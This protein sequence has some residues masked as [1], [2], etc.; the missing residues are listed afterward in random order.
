MRAPATTSLP[1][2][3]T[4]EA[5]VP[6]AFLYLRLVPASRYLCCSEPASLRAAEAEARRPDPSP[7]AATL[8]KG[9]QGEQVR[10]SLNCEYR[11]VCTR[12]LRILAVSQP[13]YRATSSM[14][15]LFSS[16]VQN[17]GWLD[18]DSLV[19]P[20]R[21]KSTDEKRTAGALGHGSSTVGTHSRLG[22]TGAW[23][24]VEMLPHKTEMEQ[25]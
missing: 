11:E 3:M 22:P 23:E 4:P 18:S 15:Q 19:P 1:L 21:N 24:E 25:S 8:E 5:P 7:A 13:S 14:N 17:Q 16:T 9:K 2:G 12:L 20:G 6:G 10:E